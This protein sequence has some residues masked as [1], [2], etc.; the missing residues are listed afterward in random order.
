MYGEV[1]IM[2]NL[3]IVAAYSEFF[4]NGTTAHII[5][6]RHTYPKH[7]GILVD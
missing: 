3:Y 5:A 6:F 7:E 2:F 1:V 4:L